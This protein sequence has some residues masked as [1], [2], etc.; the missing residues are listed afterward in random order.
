M[1]TSGTAHVVLS[2]NPKAINP[3]HLGNP[4]LVSAHLSVIWKFLA[5][6]GHILKVFRVGTVLLVV[7]VMQDWFGFCCLKKPVLSFFLPCPL[8]LESS[9]SFRKGS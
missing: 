7:P 5:E 3:S 6:N 4:Q 9:L 2:R 1:L 8:Q